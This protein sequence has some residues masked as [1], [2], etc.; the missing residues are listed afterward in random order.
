MASGP[1]KKRKRAAKA[2]LD[3][4][5]ADD[6][7]RKRG[8]PCVTKEDESAA[9]RRRTQIRLAQRA[10]RQRKES[11]LEELRKRVAEL[12]TTVELMNKTF[13]DMRSQLIVNADGAQFD[14]LNRA[15]Q[16]YAELVKV[17]RNPAESELEASESETVQSHR[18]T[19]ADSAIASTFAAVEEVS[20]EPTNVP[21]WLDQ[22][23]VRTADPGRQ[24]AAPLGYVVAP[25]LEPMSSTIALPEPFFASTIQS[26]STNP[27][28]ATFP[29]LEKLQIPRELTQTKTYSFNETSLGRRL[30]RSGLEAA[31][32]LLLDVGPRRHMFERVF[33]LSM[34][35]NDLNRLKEAIGSAMSRRVDEPLDMFQAPQIHIGGAGTH[36]PRRD[37]NGVLQARNASFD[38]GLVGTQT[39]AVL[40]KAANDNVTTD[41]TVHI[42]GYEGDW[43]D[44]YDVEGYLEEKGIHIDPKASFAEAEVIDEGS[45][46]HTAPST[47]PSTPSNGVDAG[48]ATGPYTKEPAFENLGDGTQWDSIMDMTFTGVGYSDVDTGDWLNFRLPG[49][50]I[51]TASTRQQQSTGHDKSSFTP[52]Y[53]GP[54]PP[55]SHRSPNKRSILID[56]AKFVTGKS[57]FDVSE[58]PNTHIA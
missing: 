35:G 6:D 50:G 20:T 3:S 4:P 22:A 46:T 49:Q 16:E 42:P 7:T 15:S 19:P 36:Y 40:E 23:I 48:A 44:P 29:H 17:A 33:A 54:T 41:M 31:Y 9:D 39:L 51:T 30:H 47:Q 38:L 37:Q 12:S 25:E 2:T 55:G 32:S 10:Y 11:T 57:G 13:E 21:S 27:W 52:T 28:A 53:F 26:W 34:M 45:V 43:F 24:L 58:K 1:T 8:R 14:I 5:D 18:T 56:V